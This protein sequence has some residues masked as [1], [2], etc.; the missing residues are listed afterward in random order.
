MCITP[1][2]AA[3]LLSHVVL[4]LVLTGLAE[5]PAWA[6][7]GRGARADFEGLLTPGMT[8]WITDS[9]RQEQ[10]TRIVDVSDGV[11]TTAVAE[12]I[13]RFAAGDIVRI[14]ARRSDS[15]IDGALIGA[16][17]AIA[18]GLFLCTRTEPWE[19]CR[20]DVG[21]ML[22]IGALGAAIGVGIDALI[23]GRQTIYETPS[24]AAT[25]LIVPTVASDVRG[26]RVSVS[27]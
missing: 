25:W 13:R 18:S 19:N 27:F 11:V 10:R 2:R 16:G 5:V 12:E 22:K 9:S 6:Q 24:R 20:D 3:R 7:A 1:I 17:A 4:S 21:P 14:R 15:V 8:A 23:R 26:V